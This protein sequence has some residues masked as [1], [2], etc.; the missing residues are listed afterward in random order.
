MQISATGFIVPPLTGL[1]LFYAGFAF[2]QTVAPTVTPFANAPGWITVAYVHPGTGEVSWYFVERQGG[3]E[4]LHLAATLDLGPTSASRLTLYTAIARAPYTRTKT[5]RL[6]PAGLR[7]EHT[8]SRA[9]APILTH[10]RH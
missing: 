5:N 7:H 3:G 1:L 2:T 6:V 4:A 8:P 10:P 9:L